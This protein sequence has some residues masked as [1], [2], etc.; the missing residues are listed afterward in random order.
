ML[1]RSA[2]QASE[3]RPRHQES[4]RRFNDPPMELGADP[5]LYLNRAQSAEADARR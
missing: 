5:K 3:G 4:G 2:A 1:H